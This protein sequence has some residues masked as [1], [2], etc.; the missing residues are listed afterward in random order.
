MPLLHGH[1]Q[2]AARRRSG[3]GPGGGGAPRGDAAADERLEA[4][5]Q[6]VR[7]VLA[8]RGD[9]SDSAWTR[10]RA[11]GYE[12]AQALEVLL[13]VAAYTLSTYANRLT[14]APL[15]A[16]FQAFAWPEPDPTLPRAHDDVGHTAPV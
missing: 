10:F 7:S 9:V 11:A 6:F 12:H 4:L 14:Q 15:D 13:G 2:R 1:A 8:G 5:A 3:R 16:A